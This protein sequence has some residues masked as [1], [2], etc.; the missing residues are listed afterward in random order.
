MQRSTNAS[1]RQVD[2]RCCVRERLRLRVQLN[3]QQCAIGHFTT[4]NMDL[5]G[6]FIEGAQLELSLNDIVEL[7]FLSADG[8]A[9]E[10]RLLAGVVR[11]AP[12]GVGVVLLD[13]DCQALAVLR[14]ARL[15]GAQAD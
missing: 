2:Q 1:A 7:V 15:L 11:C 13:Y 3:R 12:D 9:T 4:R 5:E 14:D 6:A 8:V 10:H